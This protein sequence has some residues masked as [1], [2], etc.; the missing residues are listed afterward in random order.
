MLRRF[1]GPHQW[2][3]ANVMDEALAWLRL[4]S[5][6]DGREARDD[7]FINEQAARV[8]D[9]A[10]ALE[11]AGNPYE[12]W[13]EF[14]QAVDAFDGLANTSAFR[15]RAAEVGKPKAVPG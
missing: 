8:L 1:D 6:K 2:A 5:M 7:S 14:R 4:V 15:E 11:H 9:R 10:N 12:S 3:P 13:Q